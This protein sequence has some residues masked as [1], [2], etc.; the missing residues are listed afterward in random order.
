MLIA[1]SVNAYFNDSFMLPDNNDYPRC[2][3]CGCKLH[4]PFVNK[5]F[6]LKKKA[7]DISS[8]YDGFKIVSEKFKTIILELGIAEVRF[9]I[10]PQ[11]EGFYIFSANH[12]L[13]F[14]SARRHTK[15]EDYCETCMRYKS[16]AGA[17]PAFLKDIK[18]PID[19]GIF[20]TDILFGGC[21]EKHPL[22]IFGINTY[23]HL[24]KQKIKG[25]D[26]K[27]VLV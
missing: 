27:E 19:Y 2:I 10:L 18:E 6:K 5:D 22:L 21:N 14:D 8:T 3:V 25:M 12:I 13:E 1:Y 7:F 17:T 20:R 26:A 24:K 16:I 11:L 15:F 4:E 9:E 23:K